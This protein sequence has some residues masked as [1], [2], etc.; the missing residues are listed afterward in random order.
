MCSTAAAKVQPQPSLG[1]GL[2]GHCSPSLGVGCRVQ[3]SSSEKEEK[4]KL[5]ECSWRKKTPKLN[6]R[7][8]GNATRNKKN[9]RLSLWEIY[10]TS[11]CLLASVQLPNK[12]AHQPRPHTRHKQFT[13]LSKLC[14][15]P[16]N[17]SIIKSRAAELSLRPK[18][19]LG[20]IFPTTEA[21]AL[22]FPLSVEH[23]QISRQRR[24]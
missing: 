18:N 5:S 24:F 10:P 8:Q 22:G 4:Q 6:P 7:C 2:P 16:T 12:P 19:N 1:L 23:I 11:N 9:P 15:N 20:H 21:R 3:L 14:S 13:F 17:I